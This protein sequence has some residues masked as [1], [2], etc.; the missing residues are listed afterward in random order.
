MLKENKETCKP[1][2]KISCIA[3]K[4]IRELQE[5]IDIEVKLFNVCLLKLDFLSKYKYKRW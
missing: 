2:W 4:K 5:I 3:K 1:V